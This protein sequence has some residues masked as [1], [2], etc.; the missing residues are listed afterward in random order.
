MEY[1]QADFIISC[2]DSLL[3][4]ARDLLADVAAEAGFESFEDTADGIRGYVQTLLF[5]QK[6]LDSQLAAFPLQNTTISYSIEKVED[7]DWNRTWEDNGF[8]PIDIDGRLL[9]VDA[10]HPQPLP[11]TSKRIIQIGARLAFGTGTH[12]TT[13]MIIDTLLGTGDDEY[14]LQ[15]CR[16]LD[17]GCG[18]GILGIAASILGAKDV[19]GYDI[20][21]W[22]VNNTRHNAEI[23]GVENLKAL[24]GDASVMSSIDGQFDIV[25]ANINRNILLHDMKAMRDKMADRALLVLSGFY[26]DDVPLLVDRAASLGLSLKAKKEKGLWRCIVLGF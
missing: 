13:Q 21:E 8:D 24:L 9:I 12:E 26:E 1:L 16:V 17:C 23:N 2:P 6:E 25:L 19:V 4:T 15:G 10:N 20:D 22:S 3:Q 5:N 7:K 11:S 14:P 18:T